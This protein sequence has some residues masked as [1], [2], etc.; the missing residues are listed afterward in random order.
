M[1]L[2]IEPVTTLIALFIIAFGFASQS[3]KAEG[4]EFV[5]YMQVGGQV[6]VSDASM[7]GG[8]V[9]WNGKYDLGINF[10]GEGDTE[11]GKHESMRVVSLTRYVTPKWNGNKT[12]YM[13]I[14]YANVQDTLLVGEHNFHLVVGGK[15]LWGRLYYA[16]GS[17]FDIGT[18]DNTGLD[19]VHI[20]FN[21]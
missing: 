18:N 16:H 7:G 20:A 12:F 10:I 13:G 19:G 4:G 21:L 1:K 3:E 14:G 15:W 8:G 6:N 17:D 9:V 11:W 2:R 5:P